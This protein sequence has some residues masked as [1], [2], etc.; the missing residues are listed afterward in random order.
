[1]ENGKAVACSAF[2]ARQLSAQYGLWILGCITIIW[3]IFSVL[4]VCLRFD[5]NR[6]VEQLRACGVLETIRISSAGYPSRLVYWSPTLRLCQSRQIC[7]SSSLLWICSPW[8]LFLSV[9]IIVAQC[10]VLRVHLPYP[11]PCK[12][13]DGN[14]FVVLCCGAL[15]GISYVEIEDTVQVLEMVGNKCLSTCFVSIVLLFTELY[16]FP[17]ILHFILF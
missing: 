6:A 12:I 13:G 10:Y 1:M 5:P 11:T 3:Q 16:F 2:T 9:F 17:H 15:Q 4:W 7:S 8:K 14:G